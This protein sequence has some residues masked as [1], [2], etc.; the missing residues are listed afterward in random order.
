MKKTIL[1]SLV[2]FTMFV[3]QVFA[4]EPP[5]VSTAELSMRYCDAP[6]EEDVNVKIDINTTYEWEGDIYD[7]TGNYTKVLQ[8]ERGCDRIVTLHLKV[9]SNP[10]GSIDGLFSVSAT[11]QVYIAK[12]NL[13]YSQTDLENG[14]WYFSNN[15]WENGNSF[16]FGTSGYTHSP[17]SGY[18][19]LQSLTKTN[20]DWGWYNAIK[21]GG[22]VKFKWYTM[23][24]DEF[25]YLLNQRS[26]ELRYSGYKVHDV[27]GLLLLPD[28]WSW[29]NITVTYDN[30]GGSP[31][32]SEISDEL[33]AEMED[34][35]AVFLPVG[36]YWTGTDPGQQCLGK[37]CG[38][39][40]TGWAIYLDVKSSS[41]S[42]VT[43]KELNYQSPDW[44]YV[45]LVQDKQ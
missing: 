14:P 32:I 22:N 10:T 12:G 4:Q 29:D 7:E 1:F 23:T 26:T 27:A 2:A 3:A 18:L 16:Q 43:N 28:N 21:N 42:F 11:E 35:G 41:Y 5:T 15:Q 25:N 20:H 36:T 33:W 45:R 34:Q 8:D 39:S 17:S 40:S 6:V 37:N 9:R 38:Y 30:P 31:G 19:P 24:Y 44:R 13:K